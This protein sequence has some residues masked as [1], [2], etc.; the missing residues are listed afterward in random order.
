MTLTGL[1]K[2]KFTDIYETTNTTDWNFR[3]LYKDVFLF[4]LSRKRMGLSIKK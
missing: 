1:T 2:V 3:I 4:Y